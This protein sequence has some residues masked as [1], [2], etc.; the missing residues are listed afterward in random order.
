MGGFDKFYKTAL[1]L[2]ALT[3][4]GVT[5]KSL[6]ARETVRST[7][8]GQI[9]R[10]VTGST[11]KP[12]QEVPMVEDY[13]DRIMEVLH[14]RGISP[15]TVG[16]DGLPG[17]G[18]STL[19]RALAKR[20]GLKWRTVYWQELRRAYPFKEGRIY[21]NIRLI[22]TQDIEHFDVI[23][24]VDCPAE[25]AKSRVI[26]RDRNAALAD[27]VDFSTMKRIGDAAFEMLDGEEIRIE[28]SPVRI[29]LRP[30]QGYRDMKNLKIRLE[31]KGFDVEGFS[32][33]ELLFTYCYGKPHSGLLP[34][35]ESGAYRKEFLSGIRAALTRALTV[36][37]LP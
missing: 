21:E 27:V 4:V 13:A 37:F 33:E 7:V 19:S 9:R 14:E 22:R 23:I 32:K 25:A 17:S 12:Y 16:V 15:K 6:L 35:T 31:A 29:K 8:R 26:T 1:P 10:V 24:Y 20:I 11:E 30:E 36:R 34:Y 28:E 3:F 2:M 18:K 5:A